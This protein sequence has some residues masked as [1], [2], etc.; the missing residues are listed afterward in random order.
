M[1]K[2][3][4]TA[5]ALFMLTLMVNAQ[6]DSAKSKLHHRPQFGNESNRQG[7]Q[8]KRPDGEGPHRRGS[9]MA[10]SFGEHAHGGEFGRPQHHPPIKM[11]EDQKNQAKAINESYDKQ[12][13]SLYANDKLRLGEFKLKSAELRKIRKDK[14]TAILT[15]EQ[16]GKIEIFKKKRE[17]NQQVMAAA[18]LE[19]MKI[20]LSLKDDQVASIK[21]AEVSLREQMKVLHEDETVL[22]ELKRGQM[23]ALMEKHKETVKALLTPEQ[24]LKL[25]SMKR[26]REG[27]G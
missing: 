12:I 6:T 23:K 25:E 18:H 26:P 1:K 20:E 10:G 4:V 9:E 8:S 16:K 14:L 17:E 22:P 24:A 21:A 2:I 5:T 19:R 15:P 7:W 27:R 3:M 11:T 13:A